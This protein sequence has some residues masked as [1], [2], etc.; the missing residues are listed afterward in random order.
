MKKIVF[1][2]FL[3]F[4]FGCADED[5]IV[6]PDYSNV[7]IIAGKVT[8]SGTP[9]DEFAIEVIY[10]ADQD[11]Y[12]YDLFKNPSGNYTMYMNSQGTFEV[13]AYINGNNMTKKNISLKYGEITEVN[14][15][16]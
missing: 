6:G 13:T 11:Q 3:I 14:F 7:S 10:D 16:F 4:I 12:W 15:E 1:L 8:E 5:E 2:L 9:A